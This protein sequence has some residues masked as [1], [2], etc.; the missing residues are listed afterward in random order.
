VDELVVRLEADPALRTRVA[1]L[2]GIPAG[3][4]EALNRMVDELRQQRLETAARFEALQAEMDRRFEALQAQMDRRFEA[5]QADM[6][7]RFEAMDRRFE[8]LQA[9]MDRRFEAMDRRF[10]DLRTG[11]NEGFLEIKNALNLIQL[12]VGRFTERVGHRLEDVVAAALRFGV[13]RADIDPG[14]VRLRQRFV[15]VEGKLGRK[16]RKAEI[17]VVAATSDKTYLMEV[18]TTAKA[19][20]VEA[21]VERAAFAAALLGLPPGGYEVVLATLSR[22]DELLDACHEAGVTLI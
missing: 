3:L 9:D 2:L 21:L 10:E 20:D 8:A 4:P 1:A 11:T 6:D 7:R 12:Q 14:R 19:R 22:S 15:D 17:D 16:G 18:R 5:L 13:G